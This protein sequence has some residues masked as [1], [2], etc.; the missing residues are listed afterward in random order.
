V[1][2]FQGEQNLTLLIRDSFANVV[3]LLDDM[4]ERCASA[5]EPSEMNYIRKHAQELA[6]DGMRERTAARLFSNP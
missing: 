4:F 3:D 2:C 1:G 5:N 6:K